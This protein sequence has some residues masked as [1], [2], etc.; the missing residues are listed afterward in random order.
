MAS[1]PAASLS[2]ERRSL[3]EEAG[4][5]W[6][7]I[8]T[9][10]AGTLDVPRN[11][12]D[13]AAEYAAA[14]DDAVLIDRPDRGLVRVFGRDPVKMVHGLVSNDVEGL[15]PGGSVH[16]VML[17]PKGRLVADLHVVRRESDLLLEADVAALPAVRENLAHYV[18]P[19][20]ARSEDASDALA[21]IGL[22]GPRGDDVLEAAR[23]AVASPFDV[24]PAEY[25]GVGG[26]DVLVPVA[27]LAAFWSA[28]RAAGARPA[29]HATLDVLRIEAGSPRWG[30]ELDA[31]VIPLEANLERAISTTKG[32]Y[33]G[34]EVIVRIL[35]RGHVN[36][37]L[38]G[39]LLGDR[40]APAR[41]SEL[42][43]PGEAKTVGRVTSSCASPRLGQTVALA[44][45]RREVEPGGTVRVGDA[46]D[47]AAARV[48]ELP[49]DD[50][51]N[52][53]VA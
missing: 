20:F 32:C 12:G 37:Q 24:L 8:P 1:G 33:T 31:D 43:R 14:R 9:G 26:A 41:G 28:A 25:A 18:P 48:V 36:R 51:A 22:Y 6:A 13:P 38:R 40:A 27:D 16:A 39:L 19:L 46:G 23:R 11:Y 30:A 49:F 5:T 3:H 4:A 50:A 17:T 10:D 52:S 47:G 34:Q 35:H 7:S 21:V 45:V 29:G 53:G 42:Y 44:Y 2:A 15:A